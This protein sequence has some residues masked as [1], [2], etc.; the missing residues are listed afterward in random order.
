M[1][2]VKKSFDLLRNPIKKWKKK[3]SEF[4]DKEKLG[5]WKFLGKKC[6]FGFWQKLERARNFRKLHLENWR[7]SFRLSGE[8]GEVLMQ[9]WMK[10][11]LNFDGNPILPARQSTRRRGELF[12]KLLNYSR[13]ACWNWK[14]KQFSIN[15]PP[16]IHSTRIVIELKLFSSIAE[17][18][19]LFN[20]DSYL[21][22][23]EEAS[24][25]R[26]FSFP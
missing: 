15:F 11:L 8:A 23:S 10:F 20:V 24:S 5:C 2:L 18:S 9:S 16:I 21:D 6:G 22:A 14:S 12:Q 13:T 25:A 4:V 17:S 26:I 19:S 1:H 3:S 7:I